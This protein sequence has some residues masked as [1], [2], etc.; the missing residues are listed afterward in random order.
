MMASIASD[1]RATAEATPARSPTTTRAAVRGRSVRRP[2]ATERPLRRGP[3]RKRSLQIGR[4]GGVPLR[5]VGPVPPPVRLRSRDLGQARRAHPA[6]R[7][8]RL[9][10]VGVDLRPRAS[11]P[12]WGVFLEVVRGVERIPVAVDPTEAQRD[13]ECL[14]HADRAGPRTLLRDPQPDPLPR[15]MVVGQPRL[16]VV[17]GL[18]GQDFE[19]HRV[20]RKGDRCR[21]TRGMVR[22]A[23]CPSTSSPT[24][25]GWAALIAASS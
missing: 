16:P 23:I 25:S 11:R 24:T 7:H 12:A 4:D 2:R 3:G 5:F 14:G 6:G 20:V 1:A 18:E 17:G 15:V 8:E 19:G 21:T 10:A 22:W 9:D 13:L